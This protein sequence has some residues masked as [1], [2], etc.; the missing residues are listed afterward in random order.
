MFSVCA[1]NQS[2]QVLDEFKVMQVQL[3]KE[4]NIHFKLLEMPPSELGVS[5][6]HKYDIESWMMGQ[7]RWGEISSC[8]NCTDYQAKRLNIKYEK[9]NKGVVF[10]H[11]VNGTVCAVP[12]MI[13]A[14][15]EYNQVSFLH[16]FTVFPLV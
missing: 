9:K 4:L 15:M 7:N 3:F 13:M 14:L 2:E 8:S 16:F 10:A 6:Y 11:T 12:R 5:A 1:E